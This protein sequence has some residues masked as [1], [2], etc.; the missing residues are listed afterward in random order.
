ML[1][2][3]Q[4]IQNQ[5]WLVLICCLLSAV[6][7]GIALFRRVRRESTHLFF[8][9]YGLYLLWMSLGILWACSGKFILRE[10]SKQLICLPLILYIAFLM[11]RKD[12]VIRKL[13]FLMSAMGAFF[14][15]LSVD[16]ASAGLSRGLLNLLPGFANAFTGFESGTRLTGILSN[17]NISAGLLAIC[18]F[19]SL[20]LLESAENRRQRVFAGVFAS[21]Q[22]GTFLLNF[23]LGATGFFLISVVVYLLFAGE[24]R[25]S[26]F[27]RM[28][29]VALPVLISVF[30]SFR[31]FEVND[32]RKV[33]PLI[34]A[35]LSAG[36]TVFLE[37]AVYPRLSQSLSVRKKLASGILAVLLLLIAAYGA[38]GLLLNG[39]AELTGGQ[40]LRRAC[41]P[42]AGD[43]T[44]AIDADGDLN[45]R[46]ITQNE[47]EVIMHRETV[48]FSGAAAD[49]AFTVPADSR[50]VYLTFTSPNSA[51]IQEAA[52]QGAEFIELHLD[53]PLLPGFIANRLQGLFANENAIQRVTF[54]RDGM[55]VF[56]DHPILGAGLGSF[57]TLL[58]GY[59]DFYYETKYVH[60]HY[61]QVLLD[62][63]IVGLLLY[64]AL[65]VLTAAALWRG[66]KKDAP[67]RSLHPSLC[68]CFVMIVLHS[69]MEVV[70]S[71]SVY[72]PFAC[73]VLSLIAVCFA[74]QAKSHVLGRASAAVSGCVS[75]VYAVL[76]ILNLN[77][78]TTVS[79]STGGTVR[80]LNALSRA[81]KI[82]AFEKNDWM[83]SYISTCAD[84]E[85]AAYRPQAEQYCRQL[86]DVPSNSL[87]QYIM[88]YYLTFQDYDNALTAAD[89]SVGFNAS[90]SKSWNS[91]FHGFAA[92]LMAHPEDE[93]EIL[94]C[95]RMLND[96]LQHIQE[97]LMEPI[98][99]DAESKTLIEAA[100]RE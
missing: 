90:D 63:G 20:Y 13:L 67:Y 15:L 45:V 17:A 26:V 57:E 40:F 95:V 24:K 1:T 29:E 96:E 36:I 51:T 43:Y 44:L 19:L 16:N 18:I 74:P 56:R 35:L 59:Q 9:L 46:I 70:L 79:N 68:A 34:A 71:T 23:S 7:S 28:L 4:F 62:C 47:R 2:M 61:I 6:I 10:F 75:L 87:H 76:L 39:D 72:L 32:S 31:F 11:P 48:L 84:L 22:A 64:A 60:N 42:E 99:L 8:L 53:Y 55:K 77:A 54:F 37:L 49:A 94:S 93:A 50:V 88:R 78:N 92:A 33:I 97:R 65:L 66:R 58:F 21:L 3:L 86:M 25:F 27:L 81:V 98:Q 14:A 38:A 12:A 80:F 100:L 85:T 91:G 73:V 52:L 83:A 41:Y 82:D 5:K 30:L 89:R 69:S